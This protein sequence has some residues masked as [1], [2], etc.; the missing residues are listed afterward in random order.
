MVFGAGTWGTAIKNAVSTPGP[1]RKGPKRLWQLLNQYTNSWIDNLASSPDGSKIIAATGNHGVIIL[2]S[3]EQ[4]V[5]KHYPTTNKW[6][7]DVGWSKNNLIAA[8]NA[9]F[10][11]GSIQ[12]WRLPEQ[13]PI[14]TL[15]KDYSMR[16]VAWSPDGAY[17]ACAGHS[18]AIEIWDPIAAC[19]VNHYSYGNGNPMGINRIK[20]SFDARYIACGDDNSAVHVWEAATGKQVTVYAK[21]LDRVIDI[22]WCP[23]K[24][25]IASA[26][27]DQT[28]QV[29]D[30]LSGQ[31]IATYTGHKGAIHSIDWSPNKQY[32]VSGSSDTTAQIW[33]ALTG[34]HIDTYAGRNSEVLSVCWSNNGNYI[35]VGSQAQGI[36]AWQAPQ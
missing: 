25:L 10:T 15:H 29:W 28:A 27:A 22:T 9:D 7:N 20:W 4:T 13:D 32:L 14:L 3:Q 17:L 19:L 31:T 18:Q 5:V 30:A 24:H 1:Q 6:V 11:A 16:T 33:D 23:G 35:V 26:S 36:E 12:V 8:A 21:H 34:K 2:D